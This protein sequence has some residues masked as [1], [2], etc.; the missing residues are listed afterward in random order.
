MD[1]VALWSK[2]QVW[3]QNSHVWVGLEGFVLSLFNF[4][5]E[6]FAFLGP[7][8]VVLKWADCYEILNS[9]FISKLGS[10]DQMRVLVRSHGKIIM[11]KVYSLLRSFEAQL[12][13]MYTS[14]QMFVKCN[15]FEGLFPSV[16]GL[17]VWSGVDELQQII[18]RWVFV[19]IG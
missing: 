7:G 4:L 1:Q 19:Q 12:N 6:L 9:M 8:K 14:S 15:V 5:I 10:G 18:S 16:D 13:G 3:L 2:G 17:T 11:S